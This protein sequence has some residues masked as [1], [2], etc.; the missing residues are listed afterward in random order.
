MR[1][2]LGNLQALRGVACLLVVVYHVANVERD[3]GLGFNPLRPFLWF[4]YAGVDLFFVLS[5]FIIAATSRAD[6]GRSARL[7]RF[8]FRRVWRIYPTYWAALAVAVGVFAVLSPDPLITANWLWEAI[9][10][11]LLLP[12]TPIPRFVPVAWSLSYELMFYAVFAALFLLPRRAAGPVLLAWA[13]LVLGAAVAGYALR[14]R[15]GALVLSWYVLEFLAGVLLAW[16][17]PR[18]TGRQAAV[19]LGAAAAWAAVGSV[20]WFDPDPV[21]LTIDVPRRVLV[22]GPAAGL[23]VC[24]AAGWERAGGRLGWRWLEATGDA[25][26]SVYLVHPAALTLT[27]YLTILVGWSHRKAWHVGWVG[28]MVAAGVG[29]GLLFHQ[30]V[31]RP[32]LNLA[33]RRRPAPSAALTAIPEPAQLA[34]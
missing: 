7:P 30:W 16:R 21:R 25:S 20:V 13:G 4:G 34:A 28:V 23:V 22:F 8:A 6:L 26:Y 32:L 10:T 18:L 27:L 12:Q 3:F 31:E 1:D 5:G 29:A 11:L 19:A 24:A 14:E 17:T 2:R 9:D 33:K 15:F